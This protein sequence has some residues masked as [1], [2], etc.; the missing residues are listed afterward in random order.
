MEG[1]KSFQPPIRN[2]GVLERQLPEL[3]QEV[4][5]RERGIRDVAPAAWPACIGTT[6]N[7]DKVGAQLHF[8]DWIAL[9][10]PGVVRNRLTSPHMRGPQADTANPFYV[11]DRRVFRPPIDG[12]PGPPPQA[13]QRNPD[14]QSK[15][16]K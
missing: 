14:E 4:K 6:S 13:D 16:R 7:H 8:N 11:P 5:L 12:R 3:R 9:H 10:L 1:G 2:R 15:P